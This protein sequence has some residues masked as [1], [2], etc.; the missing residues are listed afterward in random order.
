MK[1]CN[2]HAKGYIW[3]RLGSVLDMTS[4]L[5]ENDIKDDREKFENINL[6]E[7]DWLPVVHL[8]FSDDLTV[9]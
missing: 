9:A 8:Y 1:Q 3:K 7:D 2:A 5:E 6:N 4:T